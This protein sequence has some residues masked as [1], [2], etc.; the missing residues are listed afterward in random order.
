[1]G[2]LFHLTQT[3]TIELTQ[4]TVLFFISR[5]HIQ[6]KLSKIKRVIEENN[7]NLKKKKPVLWE[8]SA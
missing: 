6:K 2:P 8:Q 4:T 7:N 3:E 5:S 1:M